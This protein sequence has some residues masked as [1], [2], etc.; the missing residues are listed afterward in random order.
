LTGAF[1]RLKSRG[2]PGTVRRAPHPP[3]LLLAGIVLLYAAGFSSLS[4]RRD[5]ALATGRFDLGNMAQAVWSTAHG[6]PLRATDLR[7]EQIS[8][9]AAHVDPILALLVHASASSVVMPRRR[10]RVD[11]DRVG[12]AAARGRRG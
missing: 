9:L 1:E 8:R 6:Q 3:E 2:W 4:V 12:R 10:A 7:S 11:A 5:Q